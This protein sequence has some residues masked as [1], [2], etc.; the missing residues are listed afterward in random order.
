M[1]MEHIESNMATSFQGPND[2]D[3]ESQLSEEDHDSEEKYMSGND[4]DRGSSTNYRVQNS[5]RGMIILAA[6]SA[7]IV[8]AYN[9]IMYSSD[10]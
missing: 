7:V 4:N 1:N 10:E 8:M 5:P 2:D 3:L 9:Y 6:T